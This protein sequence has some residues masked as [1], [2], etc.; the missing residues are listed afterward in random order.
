MTGEVGNPLG[1]ISN[2]GT[3]IES[4][5][6]PCFGF[7]W[8]SKSYVTYG[9]SY[10]KGV[11]PV[12]KGQL[13]TTPRVLC[14]ARVWLIW[15]PTPYLRLLF[16]HR[17]FAQVFGTR[18][19]VKSHFSGLTISID[20]TSGMCLAKRPGLLT[21]QCTILHLDGPVHIL[22]YFPR[23][24][25]LRQRIGYVADLLV[26]SNK[27]FIDGLQA[28]MDDPVRLK[29]VRCHLAS[30]DP[31][32]SYGPNVFID[33][34]PCHHFT[35]LA[36]VATT[37]SAPLSIGGGQKHPLPC[38]QASLHAASPMI[39]KTCL[40]LSRAPLQCTVHGILLIFLSNRPNDKVLGPRGQVCV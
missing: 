12:P 11:V 14:N 2:K 39:S 15:V 27:K 28:L 20:A 17:M 34:D 4:I 5:V 31:F 22:H 26:H 1:T 10:T 40:C 23:L 35:R 38:P 30:L 8:L 25:V 29:H 6:C 24:P 32:L 9:L 3:G 13:L 19:S 7:L 18:Y 16:K 33:P 21:V 36:G 37:H